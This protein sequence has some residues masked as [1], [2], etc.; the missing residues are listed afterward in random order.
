MKP[1]L[2]A[3]ALVGSFASSV[4]AQTALWTAPANATS[5]AQGQG[6][7]YRLY[8]NNGAPVLLV[9]VSCTGTAP[10]IDCSAPVPAAQQ[11]LATS[12]GTRIELTA[13]APTT[14]ESPRSAAFLSPPAA[15]L[16]LRV[17]P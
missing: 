7:E 1:I 9:G 11:A 6:L 2:L 4:S 17:S 16:G 12:I 10:A 13:K 15:P 14:E 8:L 3:L 5:A